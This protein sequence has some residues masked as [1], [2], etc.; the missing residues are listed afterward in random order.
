MARSFERR[1]FA[2]KQTYMWVRRGIKDSGTSVQGGRAF[3]TELAVEDKD[4]L[5]TTFPTHA[6][7]RPVGSDTKEVL[8][9]LRGCINI[10]RSGDM[11]TMIFIIKSAIDDLVRR[12]LLLENS[13]Q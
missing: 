5:L 13:V 9:Q 2:L 4:M 8:L 11:A 10:D 1:C 7:N 6:W 12:N 3:G